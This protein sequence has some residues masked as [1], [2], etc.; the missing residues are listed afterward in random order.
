MQLAAVKMEWVQL[1]CQETIV[2]EDAALQWIYVSIY[3]YI[4]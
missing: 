4:Y 2:L 3:K 1:S